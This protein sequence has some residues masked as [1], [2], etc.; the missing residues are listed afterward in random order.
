M[1]NI[2]CDFYISKFLNVFYDP[3]CGL[4]CGMLHVSLRRMCIPSLL[5]GVL[6]T[7]QVVKLIDIAV[8]EKHMLKS[9]LY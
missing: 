7:C 3:E 1:S 6:K 8:T 4:S 9:I 2:L 5:D